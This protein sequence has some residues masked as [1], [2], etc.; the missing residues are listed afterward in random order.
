[1]ESTSFLRLT[2]P[3]EYCGFGGASRSASLLPDPTFYPSIH[4]KLNRNYILIVNCVRSKLS[5]QY[6]YSVHS[7]ATI[8]CEVLCQGQYQLLF[9]FLLS[10]KLKLFKCFEVTNV[11]DPHNFDADPDPDFHF[12]ADPDPTF[13]SDA[14]PNPTFFSIRILPL[15]F[16][17]IWTL[18]CSKMSH[19]GFHLFNLMRVRTRILIFTLMRTR[20]LRIRI[21]LPKMVRIHVVLDTDPKHWK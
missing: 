2:V 6:H 19:S 16:S 11:A 13:H 5:L 17:L 10:Q 9:L 3:T 1:M 14:D 20:I 8:M 15:T 12:D 7:L 18:N 21:Q 4:T